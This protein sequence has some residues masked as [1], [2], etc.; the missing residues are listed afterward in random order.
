MTNLQ[1]QI[2][3]R[4]GLHGLLKALASRGYR[5]V[6]PTVRDR[7]IVYDDITSPTDLPAGWTDDQDNGRYRLVRRYPTT[8]ESGFPVL[9][10]RIE[11]PAAAD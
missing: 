2:L 9:L 11:R 4:D 8:R 3:T 6:G 5:V 10:Y 7:A 1:K